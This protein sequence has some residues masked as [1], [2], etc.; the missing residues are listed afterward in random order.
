MMQT[1][2]KYKGSPKRTHASGIWLNG[3]SDHLPVII[4]LVKEAK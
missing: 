2:G 4:Y 3:Y 1:E